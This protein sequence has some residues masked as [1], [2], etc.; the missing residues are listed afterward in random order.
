MIQQ[1]Q[2]QGPEPTLQAVD[3][4]WRAILFAGDPGEDV[5]MRTAVT[6]LDAWTTDQL[7]AEVLERS[8]EDTPALRLMQSTVLQSLLDALDRDSTTVRV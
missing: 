4:S 6:G 2:T 1:T 5:P 8:A 7:F 3:E